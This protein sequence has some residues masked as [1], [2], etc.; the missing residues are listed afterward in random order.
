MT[1]SGLQKDQ[2]PAVGDITSLTV[3]ILSNDN[4]EGILEFEDNFVNLTGK[5]FFFMQITLMVR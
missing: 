5:K 4:V 2:P 1:S 3:V